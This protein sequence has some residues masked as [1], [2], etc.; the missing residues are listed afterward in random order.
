MFLENGFLSPVWWILQLQLLSHATFLLSP[1]DGLVSKCPLHNSPSDVQSRTKQKRVN[2]IIS[3]L[4]RNFELCRGYIGTRH[5]QLASQFIWQLPASEI[6]MPRKRWNK[7][8]KA[9]SSSS[10]D[11]SQMTEEINFFSKVIY[12]LTQWNTVLPE[13]LTVLR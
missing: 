6:A 4:L 7:K 2:M 3:G 8:N 5:P 13:N 9:N 10:F 11:R 1:L 12:L